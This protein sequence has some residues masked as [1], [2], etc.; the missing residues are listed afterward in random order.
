MGTKETLKTSNFH[1][2]MDK[3]I[4]L[5]IGWQDQFSIS[6]HEESTV[7][8]MSTKKNYHVLHCGM[9]NEIPQHSKAIADHFLVI[10]TPLCIRWLFNFPD[11]YGMQSVTVSRILVTNCSSTSIIT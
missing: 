2:V 7:N 10:I 3:G 6:I 5:E 1:Q 11:D 8:C 4:A 9:M